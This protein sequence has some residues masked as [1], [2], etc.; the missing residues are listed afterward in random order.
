MSAVDRPS[1]LTVDDPASKTEIKIDNYT[2]L[3]S[4]KLSKYNY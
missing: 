3:I 4:I 1:L 2:E